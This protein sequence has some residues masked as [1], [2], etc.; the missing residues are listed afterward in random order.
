VA[1]APVLRPSTAHAPA[2]RRDSYGVEEGSPA[3]HRPG[4]ASPPNVGG[5]LLR[6][7]S[8]MRDRKA[9][10]A[11]RARSADPRGRDRGHAAPDEEP[12]YYARRASCASP[13]LAATDAD[14]N[15][16][17]AA[18]HGAAPAS[19]RPDPLGA[20]DRGTATRERAP[21]ASGGVG[22]HL[23]ALAASPSLRRP[24]PFKTL[25]SAVFSGKYGIAKYLGRG[26]SAT[27]WEATHSD[28]NLRVAV[29]VFDQGSRDRRQAHREMKILSRMQHPRVVEAYEV[30]ESTLYAQLVCEYVDGE[31]LRAFA[32]RQPSHRL[33][34]NVARHFYHQVVEGIS[35]CH[36]R[37]VVHRDLKLENV[38]LDRSQEHIKIIDFGFAAQVASK[39]AKL[40]AFC[41]TPSYMAPEIIRGEGYSGFATD[42]WALGVVIF[43]LLVGALPFVGR[44]ELQLYA[45]IRRGIFTCPDL[46]GDLARRLVKGTLRIEPG[47]RPSS[48]AVLRHAWV[49]GSTEASTVVGANPVST[50]S[51]CLGAGGFGTGDA[52]PYKE[53]AGGSEDGSFL[54]NSPLGHHN[55]VVGHH[56]GVHRTQLEKEQ[57][58]VATAWGSPQPGTALGGC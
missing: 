25:P 35:Y 4:Q 54:T 41:G 15:G 8:T 43:A 51:P 28:S 23:A 2:S 6:A 26:A 53:G 30:I 37:L 19:A 55:G 48:L 21:R 58:R 57:P 50:S 36:E 7:H 56:R 47:T 16:D 27:V 10:D 31:S 32:Q 3:A 1:A 22:E 39:D 44:T 46:L 5:R 9:A 11:P 52:V 14:G 29:K 34:E 40:R 49:S 42:V 24:A 20:T 18:H 13:P 45:K 38:L 17:A 33:A 12:P